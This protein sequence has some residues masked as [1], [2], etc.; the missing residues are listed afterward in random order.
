MIAFVGTRDAAPPGKLKD[1]GNAILVPGLVNAH[2]HLDLTVLRDLLPTSDFFS[3]IRGLVE[4][5]ERHMDPALLAASTRMGI[6]AGVRAGVTTFGDTSDSS[7]AFHAML[8]TGV[9]GIAYQEVFGPDPRQCGEAM[10]MLMRN[11]GALRASQDARVSVGISPHAPY[12]VSDELYRACAELASREQL[13]IAVHIAESRVEED[14]VV[15]AAGPFAALLRQRGIS[16]TPRA[17]SSIELLRATGVLN[18][19]PLLIHA[20]TTSETDWEIMR[21][22]GV[23]VAHCPVANATLGHGV[24]PVAQYLARGITVALGSDSMA[25]N[26][27]MDMLNEARAAAGGLGST[28]LLQLLTLEGARALGLDAVTGSLEPGKRADIAAFSLKGAPVPQS[29]DPVEVL[30]GSLRGL[31]ATHVIVDGRELLV[32]GELTFDVSKDAEVF[33]SASLRM[34]SQVSSER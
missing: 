24:A 6:A 18:A 31:D 33:D 29:F 10:D 23:A 26:K 15:R 5:K 2:S 34:R 21:T 17:A 4:L 27:G 14:Y 3:W 13:R 19:R 1:L 22:H 25:A 7:A 8:Q 9:R 30:I 16:V 20:I 12:T 32:D 11:V 28:R